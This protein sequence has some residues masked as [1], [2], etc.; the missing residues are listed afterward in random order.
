MHLPFLPALVFLFTFT[1]YT[2]CILDL[3]RHQNGE[4]IH[5]LFCLTADTNLNTYRSASCVHIPLFPCRAGRVAGDAEEELVGQAI[6]TPVPE[7]RRYP[8]LS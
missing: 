7:S 3:I 4:H 1:R 5:R 6:T 2:P 8:S